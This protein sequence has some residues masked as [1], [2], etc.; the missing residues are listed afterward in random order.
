MSRLY[1]A[2]LLSIALV[3]GCAGGPKLYVYDGHRIV[4]N[5]YISFTPL[6]GW[7]TYKENPWHVSQSGEEAQWV[8]LNNN[9]IKGATYEIE[10][11]TWPFKWKPYKGYFDRNAEFKKVLKDEDMKLDD[12]DREQGIGYVRQWVSYIQGLKCTEGVFS[13]SPVGAMK[14]TGSKNYSLTCGYYDKVEGKRL[15]HISYSYIYAGGSVRHQKDAD[16]PQSELISLEQAELGLK[17]AVKQLISTIKIKNF[18]RKRM[19]R[20]GLMH[21]DKYYKISP[22]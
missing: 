16:T 22:F 10:V 19:E 5:T 4:E 17:Q 6:Q 8:Y 1:I 15:L 21:Y 2:A 7:Y 11:D 18:D 3:S 9:S 20:E 14:G 12:N 13:R